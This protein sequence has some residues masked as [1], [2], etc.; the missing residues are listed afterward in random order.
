MFLLRKSTRGTASKDVA[1]VRDSTPGAKSLAGV[2]DA[3][4]SAPPGTVFAAKGI[5]FVVL[6][7]DIGN[8]HDVSVAAKLA[9]LLCSR[10]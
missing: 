7:T 3:A 10:M 1:F 4:V 9:A 6:E 5:W 8:K 2:C